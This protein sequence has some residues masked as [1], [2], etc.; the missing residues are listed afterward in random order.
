MAAGSEVF[1][2]PQRSQ[3][4]HVPDYTIRD[5]SPSPREH[6]TA[7]T[8]T[9]TATSP[10]LT[11]IT[12]PGQAPASQHSTPVKNRNKASPRSVGILYM[13]K[14]AL[15]IFILLAA[16]IL[17]YSLFGWIKVPELTT[18][19]DE[20]EMN[21]DRLN[22]E[23]SELKVQLGQLEEEVDI[24]EDNNNQLNTTVRSLSVTKDNLNASAIN[25][26]EERIILNETN[27]NLTINKENLQGV[28]SELNS[29][30]NGLKEESTQLSLTSKDLAEK[31][32]EL[33]AIDE[34]LQNITLNLAANKNSLNGTTQ[35]LE[36]DLD[37]LEVIK[38]NLT[39]TE[40]E[41]KSENGE[42][43]VTVGRLN[44]D[45]DEFNV[46]LANLTTQNIRLENITSSLQ[47]LRWDLGN[48]TS[49][50]NSTVNL[51]NEALANLTDANERLKNATDELV[52]SYG[53]LGNLSETN[54]SDQTS[55]LAALIETSDNIQFSNKL[56]T[57]QSREEVDRTNVQLWDCAYVQEFRFED[58]LKNGL[59]STISPIAD[60]DEVQEYISG[61]L[62]DF[63]D[64]GCL[65]DTNF[66]EFFNYTYPDVYPNVNL[67]SKMLIDAVDDYSTNALSFYY[68]NTGECG[69]TVEEWFDALEGI[70][71][72]CKDLAKT[73]LWSS[74]GSSAPC[75]L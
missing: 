70:G 55:R 10:T 47:H 29:T 40:I 14:P 36:D 49:S 17:V 39:K 68:P 67:T 8:I 71:N 66:W 6:V 64:D 61:K 65:N 54:L 18:Q 22:R 21:V 30:T 19:A 62:H 72:D 57:L 23:I 59:N 50:Q 51:L 74:N 56:T 69:V 37:K 60:Y 27:H 28:E 20:L 33:K 42:L 16:G 11:D 2:T 13:A 38:Q 15:I 7:Y 46:Q 5:D 43:M 44:D 73:Y 35:N 45:V 63:V 12:S 24:F 25:L 32:V 58:W 52:E 4:D 1:S 34:T 53:L 3:P 31:E 9:S 75:A 26:R 41:L 48:T